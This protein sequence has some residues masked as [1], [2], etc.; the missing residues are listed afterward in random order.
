MKV[1]P[2]A[3][4]LLV[5]AD[6]D[7]STATRE[8]L[9]AQGVGSVT[10]AASCD[11]AQAKGLLCAAD[12]IVLYA[13][14]GEPVPAN[15]FGE[16][17]GVPAVLVVEQSSPQMSRSALRNGY[18]AVMILPVPARMLYRRI[19]SAMQRARRLHRPMAIPVA[20]VASATVVPAAV[21]ADVA[22]PVQVLAPTL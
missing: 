14:N 4:I 13:G 19:G 17:N 9:L 7:R 16:A 3:R 2:T 1:L 11:D 22:S 8:G 12:A 15:P 6:K 20:A 10:E 5:D 21:V 18:E